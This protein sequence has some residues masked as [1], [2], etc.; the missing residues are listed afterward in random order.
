LIKPEMATAALGP[1][2]SGVARDV[3]GARERREPE[4]LDEGARGGLL[5]RRLSAT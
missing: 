1:P 4:R 3:G 5:R 2:G